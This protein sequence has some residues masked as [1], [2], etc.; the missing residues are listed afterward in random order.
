MS[1]YVL[2]DVRMAGFHFTGST[3]VFSGVWR[4]VGENIRASENYPRLVGETGGKDFIFAHKTAEVEP[5]VTAM[6]RGAFEYQGQKCSAA[7]RVY[8]PESLWPQV[9]K[10]LLDD[11]ASIHIGDVKDF[12]NFMGAVIDEGS[13]KTIVEYIDHAKASPDAEVL[14]GGYDN[15][16]G[17]FVYPTIIHAKTPDFRTMKEEIFGP[18]LTVYV[19]PDDAFEATMENCHEVTP[20]AL[21][22]AIFAQDRNVIAHMEHMLAESAGNF[23]INDK[24]T[25]AVIGQQPFGGSRASGTNDKAG[26]IL[27]LLRWTSPRAIKE[28]FLPAKEFAYPFMD[29]E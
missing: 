17:W 22:G 24:P 6:V 21:T 14:C 9:K 2:K 20:Y 12:R 3:E 18:V 19:Y 13:Y 7:S 25:G 16:K 4:L 8:V 10:L 23:Y 28:S 15:T 29:E 5:L 11:V 26:S 27:N 1:E